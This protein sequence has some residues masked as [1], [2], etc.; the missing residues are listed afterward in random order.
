ML[1]PHGSALLP[2]AVLRCTVKDVLETSDT[3]LVMGLM[4]PL[5]PTTVSCTI[6]LFPMSADG[7]VIFF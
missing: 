5:T 1:P 6:G 2:V 7:K 3:E 4:Y